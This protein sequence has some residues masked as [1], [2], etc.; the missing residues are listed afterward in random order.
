MTDARDRVAAGCVQT[1]CLHPRNTAMVN[2]R[3]MSLLPMCCQHGRGALPALPSQAIGCSKTSLRARLKY[4]KISVT[5][6]MA[7]RMP[8]SRCNLLPKAA[9]GDATASIC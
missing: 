4:S 2:G 5:R 7:E 8:R 9:G 1:G 3:K 6:H